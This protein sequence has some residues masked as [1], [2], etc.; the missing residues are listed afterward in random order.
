MFTIL[1]GVGQHCTLGLVLAFNGESLV[2]WYPEEIE[3]DENVT[4]KCYV[5]MAVPS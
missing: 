2:W 5:C 3:D 1:M 4:V